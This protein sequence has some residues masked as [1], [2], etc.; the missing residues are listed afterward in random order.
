MKI[1]KSIWKWIVPVLVLV[2][3]GVLW[4][5]V[6]DP[7]LKG[8]RAV[9][10]Q[11]ETKDLYEAPAEDPATSLPQESQEDAP[12]PTPLPDPV[13]KVQGKFKQLLQANPHTIGWLNAG[14][15]IDYAIVQSDNE[16]YLDH[17]FFGESDSN[18][19]LFVNEHNQI[20]PRDDVILIHGHNM[21]DGDM[22]GRLMKYESYDYVCKHPIVNFRTL[23]DEEDVL[24]VPVSAFNASMLPDNREY[25]DITQMVFADDPQEEQED[26]GRSS[27][28]YQQYLDGILEW[29]LWSSA[30][31]VNVEDEL[32]ILVTCSYEQ[33]DGRF[34][35]ILRK[36]REGETAQGM[37]DLFAQK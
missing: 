15:N 20:W 24:Y 14:E 17:D 18:G 19:T 25:F 5:Q 16:F 4:F 8:R 36:L 35:L 34:M 22:F 28:E 6:G 12:A 1:N 3:I 10:T 37:T 33:E 23:Y 29:S 11:G 21:R 7:M 26:T 32:L 31:D 30:A 13:L 2:V 27:K 9:K